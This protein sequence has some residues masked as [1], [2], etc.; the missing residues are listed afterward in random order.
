MTD[1]FPLIANPTT[2]RIEE[3]ASGDNL[4]LQ[5]SG[6][7][8]ATTIT[9]NKFVGNLQGNA[10]SADTLNNAANITAGT[11][12]SSRLN[13]YYGISVD[14][15]NI[16]N[17][18]ANIVTGTIS[19]SRLGGSY[20]IDITGTATTA[21]NLTSATNILSGI[22]NSDRLLGYYN[23]SVRSASIAADLDPGTYAVNISGNAGTA[24][25]LS[26]AA[27]I[28]T[29][30]ISSSRLSG[31]YGIDITGTATTAN[32]LSNAANITT[33]TISSS[34]LSGSYGINITG[35]ATTA[36]DVIGGIA[37]ITSLSVS[38]SGIS[39]LGTVKI[40]SGIVTA[41]TPTG[42]VTYYGDGSTLSNIVT[43]IT[44]GIG[45]SLTPTTGIGIV[46][47]E[48]YRPTGKTIFVSQNGNDDNTGLAV[49]HPKRLSLIHISEP[50]RQVR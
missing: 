36:R 2:K 49:N 39:T 16:L 43:K 6:I 5:N 30:T 46:Q 21:I 24:T 45:I 38:T 27:N 4:N 31:S 23:I 19:S 11:I 14:N 22:I 50:T 29:G 48:S 37:S 8:G 35:T 9:A 7:V 34:R 1:R 15:A 13:G 25:T 41:T 28:T 20:G 3:L 32:N 47:V 42:I 40:S 18:A 44:A 10:T 26:N 33:G 17:N 12:S